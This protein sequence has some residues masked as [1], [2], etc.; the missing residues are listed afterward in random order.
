MNPAARWGAFTMGGARHDE[1][2]PIFSFRYTKACGGAGSRRKPSLFRRTRMIILYLRAGMIAGQYMDIQAGIALPL[3]LRTERQPSN[4]HFH[5]A[6]DSPPIRFETGGGQLPAFSSNGLIHR[7]PCVNMLH[8]GGYFT[9]FSVNLHKRASASKPHAA[10]RTAHS[11][12][13]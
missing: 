5:L 6:A 11:G 2:A 1:N 13:R 10:E 8:S 7:P 9:D 3:P 12:N 4:P